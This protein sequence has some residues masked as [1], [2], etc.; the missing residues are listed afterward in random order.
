MK[1]IDLTVEVI[2]LSRDESESN[3][4]STE[5]ECCICYEVLSQGRTIKLK[6]GHTYQKKC[7][8]KWAKKP[9]QRTCPMDRQLI[10]MSE[11]YEIM[12]RDDQKIKVTV[13]DVPVSGGWPRDFGGIWGDINLG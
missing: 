13:P 8:K 7:M 10:Q 9:C 11:L 5:E 1:F 2:D 6:C 3:S 12:R 4:E